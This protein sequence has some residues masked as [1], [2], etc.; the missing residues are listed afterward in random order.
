ME[1]ACSCSHH[2]CAEGV[3]EVKANRVEYEQGTHLF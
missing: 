2:P 3:P 1:A